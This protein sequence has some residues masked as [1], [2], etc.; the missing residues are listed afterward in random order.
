MAKPRINIHVTPEAD[1]LLCRAVAKGGASKASVVDAALKS[2]LD[3]KAEET[4]LA[5]IDKR[6]DTLTRAMERVA[7]ESLAQTETLALF[8]LYYLCVTP[9]LPE[10][11][12][13]A[14]EAVGQRRF[15]HF[16]AEVGKRLAGKSRY[17]DALLAALDPARDEPDAGFA[18]EAA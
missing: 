3:A 9:P 15:E 12:R 1:A 8:V 5:K 17:T 7:D 2:L 16:I 13:A 4:A 11:A 14:A 10:T 18:E 6:L